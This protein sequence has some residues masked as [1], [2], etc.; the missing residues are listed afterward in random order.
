[1]TA[2]YRWF[3]LAL[4]AATLPAS[5]QESAASPAA[6]AT[7]PTPGPTPKYVWTEC[8]VEGQYIAMT[9]DDGPSAALT[10]KLLDLLKAKG[11]KATFF[12]IG[13]NAKAHPEIVKRALNEGHEIANHSWSHPNLAKK[14]D[15]EV[16][17]ELNRTKDAIVA[18]IGQR[19]TLMRPPYGSLTVAQRKWVHED[20]GYQIILWDVDPLD[21]KRPGAAAVEQR[22]VSGTKSGSI[23]LAH[24]IHPGTVEAMPATFDAL[25][26]KG[27]KFVTVTE[28]LAMDKPVPAKPAADKPHARPAAS[29]K[30]PRDPNLPDTIT[31]SAN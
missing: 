7:A 11:I 3:L 19:P 10:P 28:L 4:L 2:V 23:I 24:D 13:E 12:L 27:Y 31:G 14:S 1:M 8:H 22:I 30:K 6:T 16:R 21:W 15:E 25:L 20:L 26:E 29:P 17:S 9:F 5:A 18:A